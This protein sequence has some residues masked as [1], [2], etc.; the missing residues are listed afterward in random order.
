MA[1]KAFEQRT[2]GSGVVRRPVTVGGCLLVALAV[3]GL[4]SAGAA[5]A[6]ATRPAAAAA[7]ATTH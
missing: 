6:G 7:A 2:G 4:G 1:R 5:T 3:V